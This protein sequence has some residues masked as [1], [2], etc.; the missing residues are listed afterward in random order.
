MLYYIIL[1]IRYISSIYYILKISKNICQS[2]QFNCK[3][4]FVSP[5]NEALN[6][7]PTSLM[8]LFDFIII[9]VYLV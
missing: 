9:F 7:Q 1:Y 4:C 3:A 8:Y 6:W 2:A 5:L